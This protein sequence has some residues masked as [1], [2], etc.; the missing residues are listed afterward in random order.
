MLVEYNLQPFTPFILSGYNIATIY[1]NDY[2]NW[3]LPMYNVQMFF[4][5]VPPL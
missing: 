2:T 5:Y 3:G 1:F 4:I